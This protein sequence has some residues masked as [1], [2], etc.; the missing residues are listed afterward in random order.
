MPLKY[1]ER[2]YAKTQ[3]LRVTIT[4]SFVI[5]QPKANILH[6]SRVKT[7]TYNVARIMLYY[8]GNNCIVM[9]IFDMGAPGMSQKERKMKTKIGT[10]KRIRWDMI[11]FF[12]AS[13]AALI[14]LTT[15]SAVAA[16]VAKGL[17]YIFLS[18]LLM[19]VIDNILKKVEA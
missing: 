3:D 8:V 9:A 11:L 14:S 1:R 2:P 7:T 17:F 10:E 4:K 12:N 18:L 16:G 19:A 6:K 13:I 15:A 5:W